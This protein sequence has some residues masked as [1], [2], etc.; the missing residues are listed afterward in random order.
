[1]TRVKVRRKPYG[2]K[3]LLTIL[4]SL[5]FHPFHPNRHASVHTSLRWTPGS[6]TSLQEPRSSLTTSHLT[7]LTAPELLQEFWHF[8]QGLGY[9]ADTSLSKRKTNQH[10]MLY[11]CRINSALLSLR[12]K[13]DC[14]SSRPN[15]T[16][17]VNFWNKPWTLNLS[18]PW[19]DLGF[20]W[21]HTCV[22]QAPRQLIV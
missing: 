11:G 5:Q 17:E 4:W 22:A 12:K 20:E 6:A 15:G 10:K 13:W 2:S 16:S 19:Q 9:L 8:Q 21:Q 18:L 3:C 1:M 7:P 14:L